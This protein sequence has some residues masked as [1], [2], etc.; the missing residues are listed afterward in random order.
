[1]QIYEKSKRERFARFAATIR[2]TRIV[3]ALP[4][5]SIIMG[6]TY[7]RIGDGESSEYDGGVYSATVDEFD[8]QLS[9]LKKR[10]TV[11]TPDEVLNIVTGKAAARSGVVLTFDDGYLDN[12]VEAFPVLK[13]HGLSAMFFLPTSYVGT[14]FVPWWDRIAYVVKRAKRKVIRL[15]YPRQVEFDVEHLGSDMACLQVLRLYRDAATTD[16]DRFEREL[17]QACDQECPTFAATPRFLN[18][19]H[20]REMLRAGMSFGSHTHTHQILS[21]LTPEAQLAEVQTSRDIMQRELQ[22]PVDVLAYPVGTRH[23]FSD[24]TVNALRKTGYRAAFS[25]YGGGNRGG[26]INAFDIRRESVG[27]ASY[28]RFRLQ[29]AL[30]ATTGSLWF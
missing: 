21:K 16:P 11:L 5:R 8:A 22:I 24:V 12:Y 7:H 20:A 25:H 10:Y 15:S 18:W 30:S 4:K 6:L 2:L 9:H 1:M 13:K 26:E 3:E 17:Q 14:G 29:T 19:D 23:T 28:S 27:G